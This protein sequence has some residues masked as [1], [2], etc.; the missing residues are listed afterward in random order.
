MFSENSHH[1]CS[2]CRKPLPYGAVYCPACGKEQP[3]NTSPL[4]VS[5]RRPV[6]VLFADLASFTA[7]SED[8]DPEELIDMLNQIFTRLMRECDREGGYLDK[9][10]GDQMMIL[11]GAPRAHEDDPLR[12]VRAALAMQAAMQELAPM[13]REKVGTICKLHIGIN[14]GPVVWG[15]V[16]PAGRTSPTV[17]GDAVNLASRLEQSS[18]GGQILVSES[19][20]L[21][22]R[23]YFDFD[24]LKPINVKGKSDPVPVYIPLGPRQLTT[25]Q[26]RPLDINI[27]LTER[28]QELEELHDCW[29]RAMAGEPQIVLITGDAGMG[30]SRLLAEF[31][32]SLDAS[33][34]DS[35]LGTS[36]QPLLL[37]VQ[38]ESASNDHYH[39]LASLLRMLFGFTDED[40]DLV[41]GRKAEDRAEVLG[42]TERSFLPRIGYLLGWYQ[43]DPRLIDIGPALDYLRASALD[44]AV[45]LFLRQS[46]RRPTLLLIDDLQLADPDTIDWLKRL[47]ATVHSPRCR[48]VDHRLMVLAASRPRPGVSPDSLED[49][50][51]TMPLAPLSH[52]GRRSLLERLLPG[53]GLPKDFIDQLSQE[54]GGNPFYLIEV[55]RGLVHSGQLVR[56][57]GSWQL[58]RPVS[59]IEVPQSIEGLVL[60]TLDTLDPATRSVLHHASV[61][62]MQFSYELLSAITSEDDLDGPLADLEQRG[63]IIQLS[64][65]GSNLTGVP[66]HR[67]YRFA[68][69]IVREVVYRSILRKTRRKLHDSIARIT[70]AEPSDESD[71][72]ETL[73][74]HYTAGGNQEKTITYNWLV[75][76]GAL[77]QFK[78]DQA[79]Q[80]LQAAWES[81]KDSPRPEVSTLRD[82]AEA[83]GD[84]STFV[85]DFAQAATCYG[86][87]ENLLEDDPQALSTF[88]YRLGRLNFYQGNADAACENYQKA[89]ELAPSN[90]ELVAQIY[91]EMRLMFDQ[92]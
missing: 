90:S 47:P 89:L 14:T 52:A 4:W 32:N 13:M 45:E 78:F 27:P 59:G 20:F 46:T 54:S 30:K 23:R 55:A 12:A 83:W 86:A 68:Q 1:S 72:L 79:F 87:V 41:R 81:L 31:I 74:H 38:S 16:G 8:A 69:Q 88:Q 40:S 57:N 3:P 17:I 33:T 26:Q 67:T 80:Y 58:T 29:S 75:A 11:F 39:P 77:A 71:K 36:K 85:G 91:A 18:D 63:F 49:M 2:S 82:I 61:I 53:R 73:A 28:H 92:I 37:H 64:S 19:V 50:V 9:T 34:A 21:R 24:A 35:G 10:V 65:D 56:R 70:E 66:T 43:D 48:R 44:I 5:E 62:G 84:T 25:S 60:A 51:V 7:A 15:Q 76:Q 22:T 6:T 42:I